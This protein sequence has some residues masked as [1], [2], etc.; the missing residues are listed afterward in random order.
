MDKFV[1]QYLSYLIAHEVGHTLGLRHNFHG[2]TLLAP[3][4]LNNLEMTRTRGMVS[5]VMDYVPVNLVPPGVEQGDYF[6]VIVGPYDR[7]AI[8]Y[9]YK[10][11]NAPNPVAELPYLR[12]IA[13]R[14]GEPE[15]AYAADEDT[16]AGLDPAANWYDLSNN[17]LVY[18]Q[19]QLENAQAMWSRLNRRTPI[20][21]ESYS[22]MR[23]MF[24]AVFVYY[25]QHAMNISLY[26]GGQ[27]FSRN[28]AGDGRLPFE[29]ISAT[30]QRQALQT[31]NQYVFAVR[32]V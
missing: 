24:H 18:S 31:L 15:L 26:V 8:E 16:L 9:G 30:K 3:E 10:P 7:W 27:S 28:F 22:E 14:S 1:N 11:F 21:G 12:Q 13:Q 19:W 29:A 4:E 17:M 23:D 25:F 6:P 5:S 32:C 2:S 20:A